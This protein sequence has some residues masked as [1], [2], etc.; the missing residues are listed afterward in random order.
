MQE[1]WNIIGPTSYVIGQVAPGIW[2]RQG[3]EDRA[4][5][6]DTGHRPSLEQLHSFL[7]LFPWP[8]AQGRGLSDPAW[9][10]G[11]GGRR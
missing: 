4:P 6:V 1:A 7:K 5:V 2:K 10:G 3:S 9:L 8:K 11:V